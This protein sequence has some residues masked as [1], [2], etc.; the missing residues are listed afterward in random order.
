MNTTDLRQNVLFGESE[1]CI[2]LCVGCDKGANLA[3]AL[4]HTDDR[5]L[6]SRVARRWPAGET[7]LAAEICFVH[8]D[9]AVPPTKR[10]RPFGVQHGANLLEHAPCGFIGDASLAFDL[11]CGNST[12]RRCHQENGVEP[13]SQRRGRFVKDRVSSW[14]NMMAA[15][16]AGVGRTAFD[17]V[18]LRNRFAV[19][20]VDALGVEAVLE[21]FEA[22][23]I[24][25]ELLVKMFDRVACHLRLGCALSHFAYLP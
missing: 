21:P 22:G 17:A 9:F 4:N 24:V 11:L 10:P 20:T 12:A 6:G 25:G 16:V 13:R 18:M 7:A 15:V 8:F 19:L 23:G 3:F 1:Q 5:S 14:V 2:R